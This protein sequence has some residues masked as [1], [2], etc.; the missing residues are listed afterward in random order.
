MS[1]P[2]KQNPSADFLFRAMIGPR[3]DDYEVEVFIP[4]LEVLGKGMRT[5]REWADEALS[6]TDF[7]KEWKL[8]EGK[9]YQIA[10]KGT[11]EGHFDYW[12]EYDEAIHWG[13]CEVREETEETFYMV[14]QSIVPPQETLTGEEKGGGQV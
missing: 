14:A 6:Y 9:Y 1:E 11:V 13:E 12:G 4:G 2:M 10:G 7:R 8:E 5:A 3:E